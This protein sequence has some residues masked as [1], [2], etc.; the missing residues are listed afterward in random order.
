MELDYHYN[1]I[2]QVIVWDTNKV[3]DKGEWSICG[4]GRLERF[5]CIKLLR[6]SA[7]VVL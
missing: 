2:V 4:G 6:S 3:I 5:H 7:V 1:S